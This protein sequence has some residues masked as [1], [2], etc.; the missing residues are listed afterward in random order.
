VTN[1]TSSHPNDRLLARFDQSFG[2]KA[3]AYTT[4][5]L[6]GTGC[7]NGENHVIKL[8]DVTIGQQLI[9]LKRAHEAGA[10]TDTEYAEVKAKLISMADV[11]NADEQPDQDG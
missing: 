7:W 4:L 11:C 3:L 1:Y 10:M 5:L 9:D 8:G 6:L 2:M